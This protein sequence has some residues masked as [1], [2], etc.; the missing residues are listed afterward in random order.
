MIDG[1]ICESI[2][3]FYQNVC[4]NVIKKFV[5]IVLLLKESMI[6][7]KENKM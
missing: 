4:K 7:L 1:P 2:R 3:I 6:V 5:S